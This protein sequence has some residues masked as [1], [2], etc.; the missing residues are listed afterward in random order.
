ML[1]A[2]HHINFLVRDI[3]SA[4]RKFAAVFGVATGEVVPLSSRGVLT[5]RLRVGSTWLV[6]VQPT[7]AE[8]VPARRLAERG[9]G[10]FLISFGVPDLEVEIDSMQQRGMTF[11]SDAARAGL[12]GWRVID[13]DLGGELGVDL[14][15]CQERPR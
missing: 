13:I 6:L 14:Q 11:T 2:V 8:G 4:R 10:V 7:D 5:S 15:L 12:D 3:E 1:E 9:E